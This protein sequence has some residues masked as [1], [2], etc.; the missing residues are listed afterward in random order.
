MDNSVEFIIF[1]RIVYMEFYCRQICVY[2]IRSMQD[3]N[4]QH[5]YPHEYKKEMDVCNF[6][7]L[8]RKLNLKKLLWYVNKIFPKENFF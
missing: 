8:N 7:V 1:F 4:M 2:V 5:L 6:E 3:V